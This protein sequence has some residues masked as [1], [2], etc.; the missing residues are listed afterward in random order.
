ME[1]QVMQQMARRVASLYAE[2]DVERFGR[3]WDANEL[4]LG[5]V[6]DV[7]DL[8]KLA[9]GTAGVRPHPDLDAA[10]EHELADCLWSLIAIADALDIDLER[11]FGNTMEE[12]SQ[13]LDAPAAEG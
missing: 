10:L 3:A 2:R 4:V 11:A 5:L 8:A 12:L 13:R 1:F 9:Q 6:G 7:G